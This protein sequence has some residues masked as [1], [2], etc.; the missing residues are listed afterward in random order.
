MNDIVKIGSFDGI[1]LYHY[2]FTNKDGKK[3]DV[4]KILFN[5]NGLPAYVTTNNVDD[6]QLG[7]KV[8]GELGYNGTKFV[9][10]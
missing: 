7:H 10:V 5:V 1:V 2:N 4:Y 9:L 3:I 8:S 6:K